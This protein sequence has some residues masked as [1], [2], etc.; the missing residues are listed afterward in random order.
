MDFNRTI[1]TSAGPLAC[2]PYKYGHTCIKF[3]VVPWLGC[4]LNIVIFGFAPGTVQ[5]NV[6][7]G[8]PSG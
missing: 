4:E 7:G 5:G 8:H 3:G 1:A 6:G 2:D